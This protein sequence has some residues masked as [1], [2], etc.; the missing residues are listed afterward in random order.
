MLK[1]ELIKSIKS[2][3]GHILLT[4]Y[5]QSQMK[6]SRFVF[7]LDEDEFCDAFYDSKGYLEL[8]TMDAVR[9]VLFVIQHT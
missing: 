1:N 2:Y 9:G 8:Y 3:N 6:L 7:V 5:P 4:I